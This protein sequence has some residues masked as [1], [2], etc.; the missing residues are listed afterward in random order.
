M[1]P[2]TRQQL[3][4]DYE[5]VGQDLGKRPTLTEYNEHGEYSS[6]PIYKRFE[7]FEALKD[8]AGFQ[9]GEQKISDE[10]LLDDL[11]R[12]AE[13]IGRSPP[14]M[15]YDEHG[16]HN[17]KTLK[18]RFGNWNEV[19]QEAGLEPTGH[20][21]HW[22]ENEPEQFQNKYGSCSVDCANCGDTKQVRPSRLESKERF[23]C[24]YDCR[25]EFMSEQTGKDTPAWEGGKVEI[26]CEYCNEGRAVRP[27]LVDTARFC[28]QV[29]MIE[30][31]SETF[32]GE[33]HPRWRG[34]YDRYY[35]PN[36]YQQR[37][38]A[39]K[40]DNHVCQR[41]G[42]AKSE[43]MEKWD[44]GP[45]VHHITRFGDFDDYKAANALS[46]LTTLCKRCHGLIEGHVKE[47]P[48]DAKP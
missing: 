27:S 32:A 16:N 26:E 6:T 43:H 19:Q 14:V 35:G 45:V 22:S 11:R 36:W 1:N 28:S 25:G 41:C 38:K 46:N 40:R 48:P 4:D 34:G 9:T 5:R 44:C 23:F 33:N 2:V 18:N 42:M 13:E 39:L 8:A 7:S 17:S 20:S 24:D 15:V 21:Q 31:R 29:C 30:W 47:L 12:V 37:A 3:I 10:T